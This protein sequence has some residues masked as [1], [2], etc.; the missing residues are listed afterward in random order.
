MEAQS[1][2]LLPGMH[3]DP[4]EFM[5]SDLSQQEIY[6]LNLGSSNIYATCS[7]LLVPAPSFPRFRI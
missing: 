6:T 2:Q 3:K 7:I 1:L 4:L 5:E